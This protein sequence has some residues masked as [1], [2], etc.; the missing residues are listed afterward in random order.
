MIELKCAIL[1]CIVGRLAMNLVII[2]KPVRVK[3]KFNY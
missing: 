1:D 3:K 2:L